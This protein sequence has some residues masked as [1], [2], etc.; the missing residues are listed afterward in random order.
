[1]TFEYFI[2]A[3]VQAITSSKFC[4]LPRLMPAPHLLLQSRRPTNL[5]TYMAWVTDVHK[6]LT[7]KG[8][9]FFANIIH[10]LDTMPPW[11]FQ[12]LR[13]SHTGPGSVDEPQG[14][15]L[16]Y[17]LIHKASVLGCLMSLGL[18]AAGFAWGDNTAAVAVIIMSVS[19]TVLGYTA[20]WTSKMAT[21]RGRNPERDIVI[22][23][24]RG[25]FILI[26]CDREVAY[27]LYSG[28]E[29]WSYLVKGLLPR[30]CMNA[31]AVVLI[32]SSVILLGNCSFNMQALV[33]AAYVLL[34]I[35]YWAIGLFQ[36]RASW[37]LS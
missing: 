12:V 2:T 37:D 4:M 34:N 14:G 31:V 24:L 9:G 25:A 29:E 1:M 6:G 36:P 28:V 10:P 32:M 8:I 23:T 7:T 33:G 13:I 16:N 35:V 11:G 30:I 15:V 27:E 17:C 5:P 20:S 22:R 19:S 21:I 18:V 3:H 26:K